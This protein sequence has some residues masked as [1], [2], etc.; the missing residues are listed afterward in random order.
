[1]HIKTNRCAEVAEPIGS[2]N[3]T[4]MRIA[5]QGMKMLAPRGRASTR[6]RQTFPS[7]A[8]DSAGDP[9][10]GRYSSYGED[11]I[12]RAANPRPQR[13]RA[14]RGTPA[15]QRKPGPGG[16][17]GADLG[18]TACNLDVR[19]CLVSRIPRM[20]HAML[21]NPLAAHEPEL[22]RRHCRG[23]A[24]DEHDRDE[25]EHGDADPDH[26]RKMHAITY[27]AVP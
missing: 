14:A 23:A 3:N 19:A 25:P 12:D 9:V 27:R 22:L 10:R 24:D 4:T 11:L 21:G 16:P 20:T 7:G 1:M 26:T 8:V 2:T 18:S 13:I 17:D 5:D 15:A 6:G